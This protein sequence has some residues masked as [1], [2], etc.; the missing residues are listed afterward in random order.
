MQK[1]DLRDYFLDVIASKIQKGKTPLI[2]L[3]YEKFI[4]L[5][6][7]PPR[8]YRPLPVLEH[9][10]MLP[11]M[12]SFCS[13][14]S[15]KENPWEKIYDG[16]HVIGLRDQTSQSLTIEPGGQFELSDAPRKNL[17]EVHIAMTQYLKALHSA[18]VQHDGKILFQGVHPVF[19]LAEMPLLDKQ[20]YHIMYPYMATVGGHGQWMM[21]GTSG[22]QVSLDYFSVEDLERKFIMLNRLAPFLNVIFANSPLL[23]GQPNGY[24]SF[25]GR[26]WLDTDN[27]RAGLPT[28]FV[29]KSFKL[30]KY[31]DWVLRASPYF[32]V[33]N[34]ELKP[35]THIPFGK[36]FEENSPIEPDM[37][38]WEQHLGMVFPEIRIKKILEIR[39]MDSLRPQD[40]MAI[41]ALTT[42]VV[43]NEQVFTKIEKL[44][45]DLPEED[46]GLYQKAGVEHGMDTEVNW[47]NFKK[48]IWKMM[49]IVLEH[50]GS[51]EEK[52]LL[53]FF[54]K[55]T[56]QGKAPADY[57]LEQY[58]RT[59]DVWKWLDQELEESEFQNSAQ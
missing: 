51:S 15:T 32:L 42:C 47:L 31:I 24:K 14:I 16:T 50:L 41:P 29:K 19:T 7:K 56:K 58:H 40:I 45:M 30:Q 48:L 55:Y 36:F 2:G 18:V 1:S 13:E 5:P 3:E 10:G 9:E 44:L 8:K 23:K 54:E 46:Y 49:E 26:I 4:L 28:E 53:P 17:T 6:S 43:Y 21:K 59:N 52:W 25:R 57:V 22:T 37:N 38:D 11:I 12:E 35:M 20:R 34:G 27:Q 33:R 39:C